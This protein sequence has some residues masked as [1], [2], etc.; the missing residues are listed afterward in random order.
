MKLNYI[1]SILL[2]VLI[3]LSCTRDTVD[4]I[5]IECDPE[6]TSQTRYLTNIQ[7]II[8]TS[9][10]NVGCHDGTNMSDEVSDYRT[11]EGMLPE[12]ENGSIF[13]EVFELFTM[14]V[15]GTQAN[16]NF[17]IEDKELLQ[18]WIENGFPK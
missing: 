10:A 18:C 8:N 7:P 11:Y 3:H 5:D 4:P 6:G 1:L 14:P 17:S 13:T 2:L 12:L 9:C 15:P 16:N